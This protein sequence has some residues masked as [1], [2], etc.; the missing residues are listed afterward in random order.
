MLITWY[1]AAQKTIAL[2]E[3][4]GGRTLIT[5]D[6]EVLIDSTEKLD[7]PQILNDSTLHFLPQENFGQPGKNVYWV[8]V[9]LAS[10]FKDDIVLRAGAVWWDYATFYL[11]YPDSTTRTIESGLLRK[12]SERGRNRF[13]TFTLPAGKQRTDTVTLPSS[14]NLIA[15]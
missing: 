14:V 5:K 9:N 6:L 11:L 3:E 8:R 12:T 7:L 13:A 15:L 4:S 2:S 1:A 10:N